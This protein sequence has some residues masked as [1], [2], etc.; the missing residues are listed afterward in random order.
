MTPKGAT[1]FGLLAALRQSEL[2]D[3][4]E[5][6]RRTRRQKPRRRGQLLGLIIPQLRRDR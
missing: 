6:L 4:A 3:E 5:Q 2:L 1:Y